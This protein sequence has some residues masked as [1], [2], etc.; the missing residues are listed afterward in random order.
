MRR[1]YRPLRHASLDHLQKT[2]QPTIERGLLPVRVIWMARKNT[3]TCRFRR[4]KIGNGQHRRLDP[5]I[6]ADRHVG[7]R[8]NGR[9]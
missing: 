1:P 2:H 9:R 4:G 8:V 7:T 3:T 6:S 5:L